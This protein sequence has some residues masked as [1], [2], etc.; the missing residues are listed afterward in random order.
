MFL[1][2]RNHSNGRKIPRAKV[3]SVD[4]L[5]LKLRTAPLLCSY[6]YH[7]RSRGTGGAGSYVMV[8]IHVKEKIEIFVNARAKVGYILLLKLR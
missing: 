3:G 5:L 7:D 2:E 6:A 1:D 8:K 4:I